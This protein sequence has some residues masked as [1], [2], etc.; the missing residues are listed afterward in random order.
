MKAGAFLHNVSCDKQS[1]NVV[2]N[3]SFNVLSQSNSEQCSVLDVVCFPHS[4]CTEG[5]VRLADGESPLDERFEVCVSG[6][7]GTLPPPVVNS[8][9]S[10]GYPSTELE[11]AERICR[12]VGLPWECE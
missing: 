1:R 4:N 3:C 7:W 10:I 5:A 9:Y 6:V 8:L 12:Q 11:K 2:H